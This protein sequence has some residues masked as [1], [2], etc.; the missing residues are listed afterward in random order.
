MTAIKIEFSILGYEFYDMFYICVYEISHH[1]NCIPSSLTCQAC[2]RSENGALV[3]WL[4]LTFVDKTGHEL[5][6]EH[7][8]KNSKR[9]HGGRLLFLPDVFAFFCLFLCNNM[10]DISPPSPQRSSCI[11]NAFISAEIKF[12]FHHHYQYPLSKNQGGKITDIQTS[13]KI[14]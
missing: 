11:S 3:Q 14:T 8:S 7:C 10:P 2:V 4:V 1:Q 6:R 9:I 13:L 12:F 5:G